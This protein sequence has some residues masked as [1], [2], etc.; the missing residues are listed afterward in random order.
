MLIKTV[1]VRNFRCA[2]RVVLKCEKLTALVGANGS[3]KSTLL[4]ALALFYDTTPKLDARDWY[5]GDQNEPIEISITFSDLGP[6]EKERFGSYVDGNELTV[7]R[8]FS[9]TENKVQSKYYGSR[10]SIPEF[11]EARAATSAAQFRKA[12]QALTEAGKYDGLPTLGT[13]EQGL[14]ALKDWEQAH[15]S[16]CSRGRDDGQ[17]FGFTGVA[18]GYLGEFTKLIYVPA[19]RD[20]ASDADEGKDSPVKEIVDLV[21]RNSLA[22]H[23]KILELKAETKRKYDEIVEPKNLVGLQNLQEQLNQ[24]LSSYVLDAKVEL[25]WLPSAD[26]QLALPKTNVTLSEDGYPCTVSRTGHGLQRAFILTMLQHLAVTTPPEEQEEQVE[27]SSGE[28]PAPIEVREQ[29]DLILCIEE[30]EVYQHPNRQRHFSTLLHKLASGSIEGVARKTQVIYSTHSPMFVGLDR[31]DQVRLF[32][33]VVDEP[34]KPKCTK[35]AEATMKQI[36]EQLWYLCG[37]PEPEFTAETLIPRLQPI[38]TPWMN[39]GFFANVVVLVEGEDDLAA[40]QGVA[41][42]RG[43]SLDER[44]ISVIPCIG[45]NNL[46]RPALIFKALGIPT[47]LVWDSD[48]GKEDPKTNRL[49]LRLVG[50]A[51]ED[52]P[53]RVEDSFACFEVKLETTLK[54]ELGEELF[55]GIVKEVQLEFEAGSTGDCLKRPSLF[56][57]LIRRAKTKGGSSKSLEA[58]L[59]KIMA[60][61]PKPPTNGV[62]DLSLAQT[63]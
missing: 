48:S 25:D 13:K 6:I 41:K 42:S 27:A 3:G 57:E 22:A 9:V 39:E 47:Y 32:R 40:I 49:L 60:L 17:F 24:T 18:Q 38:M 14:E 12:Y 20:A 37:K 8:V 5:N 62:S 16:Q 43:V 58:V 11:K 34:E 54:A 36:A 50:A 35:L 23:K 51:E 46:D 29:S 44:G 21:V 55:D 4:K 61:Q 56:S 33:K 30:P 52:Y 26:V 53:S 1:T 19:V 10:H 15:L 31:F 2:H 63:T 59:D 45:K 28:G 7:E